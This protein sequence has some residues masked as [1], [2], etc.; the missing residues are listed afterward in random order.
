MNDELARELREFLEVLALPTVGRA[1]RGVDL[2]ELRRLIESY[3]DDARAI[4]R[5]VTGDSPFP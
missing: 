2:A 5:E 1:T 4:L 3:P